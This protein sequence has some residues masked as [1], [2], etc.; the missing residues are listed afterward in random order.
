MELV[1]TENI[2]KTGKTDQT[3]ATCLSVFLF[4]RVYCRCDVTCIVQVGDA[5]TVRPQGK[6]LLGNAVS[7]PRNSP[8]GSV[9][10]GV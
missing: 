7:S 3:L 5:T 8:P 6:D 9:V 1:T 4:L 10:L 2:Q